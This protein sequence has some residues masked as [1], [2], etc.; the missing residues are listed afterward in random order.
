MHFV[1]PIYEADVFNY[2]FVKQMLVG[3]LLAKVNISHRATA[4]DHTSDFVVNLPCK[5]VL[6]N[7]VRKQIDHLIIRRYT[8]IKPREIAKSKYIFEAVSIWLSHIHFILAPVSSCSC[9]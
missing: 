9:I 3:L 5:E 8:Y 2:T 6:S 4:K 1:V 7:H